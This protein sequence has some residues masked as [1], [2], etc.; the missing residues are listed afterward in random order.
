MCSLGM[1]QLQRMTWK[2]GIIAKMHGS[3]I[4]APLSVAEM[5]KNPKESTFRR[6]HILGKWGTGT[7]FFVIGKTHNR[8]P[9]RHLFS[10]VTLENGDNLL[11]NIGWVQK[12]DMAQRS[13]FDADFVGRVRF[14]PNKSWFLP[15]HQ[16]SKR[17]WSFVDTED[18]GQALGIRLLPFYV[19]YVRPDTGR[20][21]YPI[22]DIIPI[23]N[24]HLGYTVTWFGLA[25]AWLMIFGIL[26][27][28]K[29]REY[30][31]A[32]L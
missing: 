28:R 9:G 15:A 31:Y 17:D 18:M 11:V 6:V 3:L 25:L 19:D 14:S 24:N 12:K 32:Q 13:A 20:A 27:M 8:R 16:P 26:A 4:D 10:I 1:W 7:N 23:S 22:P 21:P 2:E 30:E 29:R 5:L